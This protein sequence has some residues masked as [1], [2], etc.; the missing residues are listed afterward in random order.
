[1]NILLV[2]NHLDTGGA[3]QFVVR[4]A[5]EL[6]RRRHRVSVVSAGGVLEEQLDPRV[7]HVTSRT[8]SKSPSGLYATVHCLRQLIHEHQIQVIHTNS[9][10]TALAARLARGSM[11]LPVIASAHGAWTSWRK[12]VV[13][14]ILA[15][16]ARRTVGCSLTM[17]RDL[18]RHGLPAQRA[19][20][21]HN[22]IPVRP[23]GREDATRGACRAELGIPDDAPLVLC[24]GRLAEVKGFGYL[25]SAM[26]EL[27]ARQPE[28][29]LCIA[30][31][32]P[33]QDD[34]AAQI[35]RLGLG[36]RVRLLGR[37]SDVERLLSAADVFCQPSL[38]EAF[39]LA[40]IE[41][42]AMGLPVVSTRVGGIPELVLHEETGYLVP[43]RSPEAL[44]EKLAALI[45]EPE[46]RQRMGQAGR[47]RALSQ[48]TL[49]QMTT[50][51]E[52]LY[53][54]QYRDLN[55]ALPKKHILKRF[56]F[57]R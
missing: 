3:E 43:S 21:I 20:T 41:A 13:A 7:A 18:L 5:N 33:L 42:M 54:E 22:G 36:E 28:T 30:G 49:A 9:T 32:G 2:T 14:G 8:R 25:L 31:D 24:V 34:L 35:E 50:S 47:A 48:F 11:P 1:M 39:P 23:D 15:L 57:T 44:S 46:R 56:G 16:S 45:A 53:W 55:P 51:F 40:V 52:N 6:I 19:L 12:P 38:Y 37:R 17:T 4:L 29:R 27:L 10:N 26:P